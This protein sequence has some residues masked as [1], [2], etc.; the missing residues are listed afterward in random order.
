METSIGARI[1]SARQLAGI[2]LRALA[3]RLNGEVSHTAINKFETGTLMPD[4]QTL[5]ALAKALNVQ[6]DY[7]LRQQTIQITDIAFRKRSRLSVKQSN[8]IKAS[9][10]ETLER[11]LE[12]EFLLNL[13]I[14]FVN[15][16]LAIKIETAADVEIAAKKLLDQ[17][18]LGSNAIPNVIELLESK[19]V[20]VIELHTDSKFDGLSGWANGHVPVIVLNKS[21]SNERKRFT[22]LHEL[23]HLLLN[24]QASLEHAVI[25]KHCHRF[26]G[27]F[28]IPTTTLKKEL[29]V[30]RSAVSLNELVAI[31]ESYGI[32]IQ[33]IMARARDLNIISNDYYVRFRMWINAE[34]TR[35][36]EIGYGAYLGDERSSRFSQLIYRATA[37]EIIT[38]SKAA[39]LSNMRLAE[40]RDEYSAI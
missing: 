16:I 18:D 12:L 1:K 19:G 36:M 9:V 40:F 35:K 27:A 11:Y 20:K 26:A 28:L 21:F 14:G 2:S 38:M 17:W 33:A 24:F 23:G 13:N 15:P 7:F 8:S 25:E 34:P 37:E 5:L 32:S 6:T 29:G 39:S 10:I 22:A 31:K 30:T 3:D 4:G